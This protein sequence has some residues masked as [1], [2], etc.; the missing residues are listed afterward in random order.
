MWDSGAIVIKLSQLAK[1]AFQTQLIVL[2][3]SRPIRPYF[4]RLTSCMLLAASGFLATAG[5]QVDEEINKSVWKQKYGVLDA[6]MNEQAPY[7]G[8]LSQDADGDGINNRSE[9]IAGTNPFFKS[10]TEAHFRP[11]VVA[12]SSTSL[13][14]T[15]PTVP[16]KLYGAEGNTSLVEAWSKG[17]L[18]SV[19]GDGT[20][21][22]LVVPKSAGK[23]FHVTVTDQATQGDQVSD[24]AKHM[25]GLS[26]AAPI[27]SQTSYDHNSLATGLAGENVVSV[28][29]I[30]TSGY[31]P[32]DSTAPGSD[33][34]VIKVSRTGGILIGALTVP[35]VK[36]GTAVEGVDYAPLPT[37][38]V[39]PAGVN[40]IEVKI[41]PL[42]NSA[43]TSGSTVF[44]AAGSPDAVTADG[45]YTLG[46]PSAAGVTIYPASN[47][48]GTGLTANY[49][50]SSS[51]TYG[52]LLNFGGKSATYSYTK[53]TTTSG[54]VT[55]TYSGTPAAPL[56]AGSQVALRFTSGNLNVSPSNTAQTYTI[57]AANGSTTFAVAISGTSVPSTGTGNC[58]VGSFLAPLTR[59]DPVVDLVWGTGTP[60][61]SI[62]VDN[63]SARWTGQ[64]LPQY[65]QKYYFV[66][67]AD[68]GVKLWVNN[69]LI[70]DRWS[71]S[72][73]DTTA[74]LDLL[75]VSIT[76]SR[77]NITKPRG[78]TKPPLV[79]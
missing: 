20:S 73:S 58:E 21:K 52:S 50:A 41:V 26:P 56:A 18:P 61:P 29:P 2:F 28:F 10:P 77:W 67:N 1:P 66:V 19:V 32:S 49:Y 9:F 15:F 7:V 64:I 65:S 47:P 33:V 43:R 59:I 11:P 62:P 53:S 36:S 17:S 30:D 63:F 8:W 6:Q 46:N 68:D 48:A 39:F 12:D 3:M 4:V 27:Q 69:Q 60:D 57:T 35:L 22:T 23:F 5:A 45:N 76:I 42:Y 14:L 51:S 40:S 75:V 70:I 79:V 24:W 16:G 13:S 37:S 44:L 74:S 38:L 71:Y 31:Q 55:I 25:L 54:S 78:R 34:G 72:G